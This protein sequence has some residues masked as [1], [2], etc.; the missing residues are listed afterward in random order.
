MDDLINLLDDIHLNDSNGSSNQLNIDVSRLQRAL[1]QS[2]YLLE[3]NCDSNEN[4]KFIVE[5]STINNYTVQIKFDKE[6][7]NGNNLFEEQYLHEKCLSC[8]CPDYKTR[9][10]I[11]KHIMFIL[12]R[13]LQFDVNNEIK[14]TEFKE[15]YIKNIVEKKNTL[16]DNA[17]DNDKFEIELCV[18]CYEDITNR[19][20]KSGCKQCSGVYHTK[21]LSVWRRRNNSCPCCRISL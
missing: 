11:C 6:V 2:M 20:Y 19:K 1:K 18:I 3:Y 9:H 16:N 4:Y 12:F 10:Q 13:V 7:S 17:N 5:G 14:I 21:C 15:R 8:T